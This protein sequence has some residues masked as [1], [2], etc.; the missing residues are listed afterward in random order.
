M[1]K[2]IYILFVLSFT[3]GCS[4]I[5]EVP[6]ISNKTVQLV[7]PI[8][9]ATLSITTV[10]LSW[11]SVEDADNY[12]VQIARPD[13]EN[14]IQIVTDSTLTGNSISVQLE[15]NNTYQWRVRA[16]NS[17]YSTSYTTYSFSLEE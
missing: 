4:D 17:E 2:I 12:R 11:G 5:I 15:T 14:P 8:D 7:A 6:D 16:N 1:R 10:N 9:N 3:I 13:F